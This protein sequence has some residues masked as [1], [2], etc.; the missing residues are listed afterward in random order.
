[1]PKHEELEFSFWGTKSRAVGRFAVIIQA[2]LIL[3]AMALIAF[4]PI[5]IGLLRSAE[6]PL[7][8]SLL[9]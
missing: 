5:K 2:I 8:H 6:I 4:L 1:M 9:K 7:E 3:A